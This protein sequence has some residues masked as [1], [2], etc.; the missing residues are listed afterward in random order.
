VKDKLQNWCEV[1][2][3][4]V[5]CTSK[6]FYHCHCEMAKVKYGGKEIN[7]VLHCSNNKCGI[8]IDCDINSTR[9]INMV[10]EKM[11]QKVR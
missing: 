2:D 7:S 9:N 1:V 6:L 8:T 4:D 11:I 5:F 10:L 3:I